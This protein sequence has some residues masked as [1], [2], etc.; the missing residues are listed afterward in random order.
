MK[1]FLFKNRGLLLRLMAIIYTVGILGLLIPETRALFTAL[2]PVNIVL[3]A[4]LV[5]SLEEKWDFRLI[6]A[7]FLVGGLGFAIEVAGVHTGTIFGNYFYRETLGPM[8]MG[9]PILLG[10]NWFFLIYS[11]QAMVYHYGIVLGA[12]LSALILV[13]YDVVLEPFAIQYDLWVWAG[14]GVPPI[15][16]FVAWGLTALIL[17]LLFR[18]IAGARKNALAG[19]IILMQFTFFTLLLLGEK[20][21]I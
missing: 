16:N 8:F 20:F 19:P 21:G 15:Q 6:A 7:A 12:I 5:L 13:V 3:A 11:A 9:V 17:T 10:L 1:T 2:T 4:I 14:S 18:A